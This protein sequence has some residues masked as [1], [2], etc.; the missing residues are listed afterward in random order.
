[1][2][3]TTQGKIVVREFGAKSREIGVK[4]RDWTTNGK[5]TKRG[6]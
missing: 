2:H 1:M 3:L 4:I 6:E 5:R